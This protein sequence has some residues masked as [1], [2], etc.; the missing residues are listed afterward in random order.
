MPGFPVLHYLPE[1][2]QTHVH[3]IN[4]A[5]QP[6]QPLLCPSPPALNL[7]QHQAFS[8]ESALLIRWPNYWSFSFSISLS[9]EY[10]GLISL[11]IDWVWSPCSSRDSQ[12][13]SLASQF[14]SINSSALFCVGQSNALLKITPFLAQILLLRGWLNDPVLDHELLKQPTV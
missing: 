13:S 11:R 7:S 8:S 4:D 14:E 3:W 6:F 9:N 5:I 1:F 12:E 10:S 2:A